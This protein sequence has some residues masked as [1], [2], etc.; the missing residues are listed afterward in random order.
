MSETHR[1]ECKHKRVR[2]CAKCRVCH[3]LDCKAEWGQTSTWVYPYQ[4]YY[5]TWTNQQYH[6]DMVLCGGTTTSASTGNVTN[7]TYQTPKCDHA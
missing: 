4:P 2:Y 7:A 3:C 1:C 6:K 5:G